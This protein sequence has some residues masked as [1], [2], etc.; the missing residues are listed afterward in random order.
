MERPFAYLAL[1]QVGAILFGI[2]F[3]AAGVRMW[4]RN[5]PAWGMTKFPAIVSKADWFAHYG[6]WFLLPS[7]IWLVLSLLITQGKLALPIGDRWLLLSG[8]G[9]LAAFFCAGIGTGIIAI[10]IMFQ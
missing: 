2:L 3:S 5:Y 1:S 10:L 8:I 7:G 4:T 6:I 9:L